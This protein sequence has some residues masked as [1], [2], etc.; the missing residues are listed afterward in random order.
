MGIGNSERGDDGAGPLV[1]SRFQNP[2][3]TTLDC[4]P[5]PEN[6]TSIVKRERPER[7]VLVDAADMNLPAGAVRR[8]TRD[9]IRDSGIGTHLLPLSLLLDYLKDF[10]GEITFIAIQPKSKEFGEPM[11]PEVKKAVD[12]VARALREDRIESIAVLP[13]TA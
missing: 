10:A 2:G 5:S 9:Q 12:E 13:N 1:A 11:S 8:V 7:L 3:W 6:F 4:G